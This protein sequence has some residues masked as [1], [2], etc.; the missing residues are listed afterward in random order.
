MNINKPEVIDHLEECSSC[1]VLPIFEDIEE[2]DNSLSNVI[3]SLSK[4]QVNV[5]LCSATHNQLMFTVNAAGR[6]PFQGSVSNLP[7][8]ISSLVIISIDQQ[9]PYPG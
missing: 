7:I 1:S 2:P 6:P 8:A 5:D 3:N 9:P 4:S